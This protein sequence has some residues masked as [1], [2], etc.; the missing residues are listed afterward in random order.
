[1]TGEKLIKSNKN[2]HEIM[3]SRPEIGCGGWI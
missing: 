2:G 3:V 1:M